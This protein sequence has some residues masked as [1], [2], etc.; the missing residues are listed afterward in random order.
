[1]SPAGMSSSS[2]AAPKKQVTPPKGLVE[3]VVDVLVTAVPTN[4]VTS[5]AN[6][7]M[8]QVIVFAMIFGLGA[9]FYQKETEPIFTLITSIEFLSQKV[10]SGIM[11]LAPY[12]V[13]ALMI[14]VV[15][16]AGMD[17]LLTLGKYMLVVLLGLAT[18]SAILVVYGASQAKKSPLWVLKS[19][20]SAIL[21]AFS[22]SSSAATLPVTL[23]CVCDNLK[24]REKT[25]NFVLPLGA[26]IN[27]DG[28][29]L[30]VSVATVF[31]A[32]VYGID[33]SIAQLVIIFITA[34]L[35]AVGAAAVPGAGLI[36]MGIVL[37][38]VGIP[39]EGIQV[40]IAVDRILDMFRTVTN[41]LGDSVG[42]LVVDAMLK[43]EEAK[44]A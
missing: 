17:A 32:Q 7:N 37:S 4:P 8:L 36:T 19:M 26:T 31:I 10:T 33:L 23:N 16:N 42:S 25:A 35:A 3:T 29:A 11:T 44:A 14:D 20:S 1:M 12:G 24:V 38:S 21:T 6:N 41:V 40:V 2:K 28:T 43:K 27:M 5:M 9:L 34:S 39:L 13:C 22:T 15:A 30:Y 18:H